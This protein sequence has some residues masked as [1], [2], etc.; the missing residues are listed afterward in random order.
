MDSPSLGEVPEIPNMI[1]DRS[2]RYEDGSP[3]SS[4][5]SDNEAGAEEMADEGNIPIGRNSKQNEDYEREN[6]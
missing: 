5:K 2:E 3:R 4:L 6:E 1:G